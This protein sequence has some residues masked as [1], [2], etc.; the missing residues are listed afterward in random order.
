MITSQKALRAHFWEL[1]PELEAAAR[2]RG[3]FSKGQ[4]SQNCDTRMAWVDFVDSMA[5]DGQI[6]EKLAQNAVL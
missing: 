1:H 3:T 5:R 6:S 2:K 4:N